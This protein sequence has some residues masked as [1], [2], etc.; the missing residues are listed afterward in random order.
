MKPAIP[1]IR[2]FDE[3]KAKEFYIHFLGFKVDWEH[4]FE[5]SM[6]LYMQVSHGECILHLSEHHGDA[7]PG[8]RIRIE[9]PDLDAYVDALRESGYQYCKPG[10]P[11]MQPW[12][13]REIDLTDPFGNR[14]TLYSE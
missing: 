12:G 6:P 8:A 13:L 5:P 3:A 11:V 10:K 7:A 4:R 1:V 9:T 2:S 14:L